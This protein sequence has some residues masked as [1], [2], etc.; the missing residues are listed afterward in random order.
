MDFD[1][2]VLLV[3]PDFVFR[4]EESGA[5]LFNPNTN[6]LHCLNR[7]G[8]FIFKLCDGKNDFVQIIEKLSE[9]FDIKTDLAT[10]KR[11][12]EDFVARMINLNLLRV[13]V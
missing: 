3:N 7:V 12:V 13:Q 11:D 8:A 4:E 9:E 6:A 5:L 2:K 10:V 1:G